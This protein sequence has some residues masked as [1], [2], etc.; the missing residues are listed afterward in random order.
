MRRIARACAALLALTGGAAESAPS[1]A[2]PVPPAMPAAGPGGITCDA[3]AAR[4]E[5]GKGFGFHVIRAGM[6]RIDNPLRPLTP[7]FTQVLEVVIGH[8]RATAYGPDFTSLRRGGP[9]NSLQGVLGAPIQW[10]PQ[11]PI[12]PDSLGVVG[13]DGRP[14]ASLGFKACE[15]A[16]EAPPEPPPKVAKGDG[17]GDAK[18]ASKAAKGASA[19]AKAAKAAGP[20]TAGAGALGGEAVGAEP[21]GAP[22]GTGPAGRKAQVRAQPKAK[23]PDKTP[24]GFTMPSGALPE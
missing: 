23:T 6:V 11:L 4:Y 13:D 14:L 7:D 9:P 24:S 15:P 8:K 22:A 20:Q 5:S 10:D 2:P 18:A 21:S 1:A 3:Q 19:K 17:K 16:P 12:L